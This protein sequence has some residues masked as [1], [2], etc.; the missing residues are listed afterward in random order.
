MIGLLLLLLAAPLRAQEIAP[1]TFPEEAYDLPFPGDCGLVTRYAGNRINPACLQES[2]N[3]VFDEDLTWSRRNGQAKYNATPCTD[4]K[5]IR[6]LWP[7]YDTDNTKYLII[8]SSETMFQS[9]GNGSCTAIPGLSG[10]SSTAEMSCVQGLGRLW[11]NNAVNTPFYIGSGLSTSTVPGMPSGDKM[12]FFRNRVVV[13]NVSGALT[14]IRL[15]GEG[16]GTDWTLQIPGRSTTPAS[17]DIA[18]TNDGKRVTCLIGEYQNAYY[19]GREYETYGLY[20]NDRRDF[21]LR[22]ISSEVG[23][24]EQKSVQEKNNTKL[25]LSR[26]GVERLSGTTINRASDPIR[27]DIDQIIRATGNTQSRT[28]T[29]QADFEGGSANARASGAGAPMSTTISP[30]NVVPSTWS[31]VDTSSAQ[32]AAGTL[33]NV[34]TNVVGSVSLV[35]AGSATFTNAGAESNSTTI[36]ISSNNFSIAADSM[37]GTKAWSTSGRGSLSEAANITFAIQNESFQVLASTTLTVNEGQHTEAAY[38]IYTATLPASMI[39]L[40]VDTEN[41][42]FW[43]SVPFIRPQSIKIKLR[44]SDSSDDNAIS[45]DTDESGPFTLSGSFTQALYDTGFSTPIWGTFATDISSTATGTLTFEVQSST[46]IDGGG[47]QSL[48]AQAAD[49]KIAAASRRAIRYKGSFAVNTSTDTSPLLRSVSLSAATTGYYIT[50]CVNT[51]GMSAWVLFR[52]ND[53]PNDGAVSYALSTGASCNQVTRAT[54]TWTTQVKNSA[55]SLATA[56][57]VAARVA[58]DLDIASE[59][60]TFNDATFEWLAGASRP[61]VASAVHRDRYH[62]FYTTSTASGAK[63]DHD[64]VLDQNDKWTIFDGINAYSATVYNNQLYTGDSNASGLI[65]QQ[66]IGNDDAGSNFKMRFRTAD[67][68]LGNPSQLKSFKNLYVTLK[69]EAD[70][71]QSIPLSFGY[72]LDG[73]TKTYS[74]GSCDLG[75]SAEPGYFVCKLPF[76]TDDAVDGHWIS[77]E[78]EYSGSQGPVKIYSLRLTY[79]RKEQD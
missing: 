1:P 10:L 69:S 38:S 63:N 25:W 29:T 37:Y 21:T 22:Q 23:C 62:L 44:D 64:A 49:V 11:C 5:S 75:E 34:S 51:A 39:I 31:V 17:I 36:N 52:A 3:I 60:P 8:L 58:F 70:P 20:G 19:I 76:P 33:V 54:A 46:A 73:S 56:S 77:L 2:Q 24:I 78:G 47:F 65:H 43:Q 53:V 35:Q 15:S 26:R 14:R 41:G 27:P 72:R 67:L 42:T 68:D 28:L 66:D 6:G 74:L 59:V 71:S 4:S 48:V 16:D 55:I 12:G 13:A 18:G 79:G 9:N 7:F 61:P 45:W 50:D 30:G 40:R 57:F 32:F